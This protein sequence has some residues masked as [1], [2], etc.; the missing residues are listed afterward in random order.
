VKI[1]VISSSEQ[2]IDAQARQFALRGR[3][4]LVVGP[5]ECRSS[6]NLDALLVSAD[7]GMVVNCMGLESLSSANDA[8]LASVSLLVKACVSRGLPILQLSGSQVFDGLDGGRHREEDPAT[9]AS[10]AGA[11][12]W[13]MEE[14]VRGA[15]R[16]L[17]LRTA[18]IYS[19]H[20]DNLL[21][22]LLADFRRGG[23]VERSTGGQC[24]PTWSGDLARVISAMVDQVSCDADCWGTYH[25][26]SSDPVSNYQ[27]AETTLAVASQFLD[28]EALGLSLEIAVEM[29]VEWPRPLLNCEKIRNT[30]GIKQMPWRSS[31]S[32]VV[33]Q[34]FD[35]EEHEQSHFG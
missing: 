9:P 10:R 24:C 12:L 2:F 22:R 23:A 17:I 25:Y 29:D 20:G 5:E 14:L 11:L 21:T 34:V 3:P 26:T 18:P 7:I 19:A 1:L 30:F 6:E 27:F 35:G 32:S 4:C 13:R 28:T 15:P 8:A 31:I 16:H 33:Q